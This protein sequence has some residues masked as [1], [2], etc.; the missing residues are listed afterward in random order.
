VLSNGY[1]EDTIAASIVEQ[2]LRTVNPPPVIAMPLV[3]EGRAYARLGVE[4]IGPRQLM[5]SGGLILA[6]WS[7]ILTDIKAG[8]WKMTSA[9]MGTLK[10]MRGQI[11]ALVAVGDTYPV[12]M[13][14]LCTRQRVIMVGTAKSNYFYPYSPFERAIFRRYCEIVFARDEP[15]AAT[16]REHGIAARWVGNAMMDSLGLTEDDLPIPADRTA[17]GLLPG[18]RK[19]AFRDLPVILEAAQRL[20]ATSRM[21]FVMA[22]PDSLDVGEVARCAAASG[23][24]WI[25][26]ADAYGVEGRLEGYGQ[27]AL[28]VRGRFGDV[29]KHCRLIIGQAGTGN[30]QAVGMG[31]PVI[32]FDSDGRRVPGWYRAR[33]KG[34]LGDSLS[35]VERSGEAIAAEALAILANERRYRE[36]QQAGYERM[37]PPGASAKIAS[38]IVE[39]VQKT[40]AAV[41]AYAS[42]GARAAKSAGG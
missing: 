17:V 11:G 12:L 21:A 40:L 4:I 25:P 27:T 16:L 26:G 33:Q 13:G 7:N 28:L 2:T 32:S 15:T 35:V 24:T 20:G 19:V 8:F 30:E 6:G 29:V 1:G 41:P 34:L 37:G 38:Y 9:Q 14:A 18:S 31:K 23:W 3:G 22:L 36:M 42:M 5:P 10:R 39:H